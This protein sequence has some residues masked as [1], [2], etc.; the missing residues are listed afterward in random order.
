MKP[1]QTDK[2]CIRKSWLR[3]CYLH[4]DHLS[5]FQTAWFEGSYFLGCWSKWSIMPQDPLELMWRRPS[6][7]HKYIQQILSLKDL[8]LNS[9]L[10]V[11]MC[12][13]IQVPGGLRH[14]V[15]LNC[16]IMSSCEDLV[17]RTVFVS[18]ARAV[19]APVP[20]VNHCSPQLA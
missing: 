20:I 10:C 16:E 17:L 2:L 7:T 1:Q 15:L 9:C 3:I 12:I 18:S 5:L 6:S 4:Q 8:L 14:W 13:S 11:G 19:S